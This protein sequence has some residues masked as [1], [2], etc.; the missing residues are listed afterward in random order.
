MVKNLPAMQETWIQSLGWKDSPWRREWLLL[1]YMS[2]GPKMRNLALFNPLQQCWITCSSPNALS[3]ENLHYMAHAICSTWNDLQI[4]F[5]WWIFI[6]RASAQIAPFSYLFIYS[7]LAALALHCCTWAFSSCSKQ[8]L[9]FIEVRRLLM[10]VA[11][12]VAKHRL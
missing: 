12:L 4:L 2:I 9:L 6:F 8:E 5:L 3:F 10:A 7:F 1:Y 11:F